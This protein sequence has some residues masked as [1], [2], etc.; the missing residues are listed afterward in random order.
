M[1]FRSG[2]M[3]DF[4][5]HI[6]HRRHYDKTS[7]S[8]LLTQAGF[9]VEKVSLLGFPF[10]ILYRLIVIL[11]GRRLILDVKSTEQQRTSRLAANLVMKIFNLLFK[12]NTGHSRF[13]WQIF[14]IARCPN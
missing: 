3:S 13:G 2:P 4:D 6:G 10:F 1:L 11:R 5:R 9:N 8:E 12:F 14:A 7:I